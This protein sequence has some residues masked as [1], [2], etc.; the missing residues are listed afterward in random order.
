MGFPSVRR[1]L[2]LLALLALS[3]ALSHAPARAGDPA[4]PDTVAVVDA[5]WAAL[6]KRT[7]DDY[8][9]FLARYQ[10]LPD[11]KPR[12]L[13][14]AREVITE[15][16]PNVAEARALLGHK[17]FPH[18]VPEEIS[19]RR[20]PFVR[21]VE[22]AGA[23]R[24]F[25]DPVPYA[26]ALEAFVACQK[27]AARL[28]NDPAY[29]AL[30]VVRRGID[31][32]EFLR[33]YNYDAIFA[34]PFLICYSTKERIDEAALWRLPK[35]ERAKA[36]T[37]LDARRIPYKRVLAEKA[38]IYTQVYT[39][40]LAQYGERCDLKPLMDP[41]GGRADYPLG[42]RSFREGC[43]LVVW[44]FSDA[45][46]WKTHHEEVIGKPVAALVM[47]YVDGFSG[48]VLCYDHAP[49]DR[50]GELL[51]HTRFATLSALYWFHRQRNE[52]SQR[53]IPY[54]FFTRGFP[55]W[56][57][58]ATVAKDRTLSFVRWNRVQLQKLLAWKSVA[59]NSRHLMPI[60]PLKDLLSLEGPNAVRAYGVERW[61]LEVITLFRGQCWAFFA[62]LD[63]AAD[64]KRRP[65][66]A[67]LLDDYL[68]APREEEGYMLGQAREKLGITTDADWAALDAEF[69][70]F[71]ADLLSKDP[72]SIGPMPPALS[73][74][75]GFV[76][77][78]LLAPTGPAK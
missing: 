49:E 65:V 69:A 31:Q 64:G 74:W 1:G 46:A 16:D 30:D 50:E 9:R 58:A 32:D 73:D 21:I 28:T 17:E 10:A 47:G 39:R 18:D 71:Y 26:N 76:A 62:F 7:S 66:I 63:H 38:R 78:D 29:S 13:A 12:A 4:P 27:H 20:Y 51:A 6:P 60:F 42:K 44:V 68:M 40:F 34:S 33:P 41:Y 54:D 56:F 5:E 48:R 77:P 70:T 35:A 59:T 23:Q 57:S 37:E 11:G 67:K 55:D 8:R 19:Y 2:A 3:V 52:W 25:D 15:V 45:K 61:G 36:W 22:E 75:P 72:A 53:R 14:L 43:P 24:W